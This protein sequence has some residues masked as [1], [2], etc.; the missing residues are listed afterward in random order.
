MAERNNMKLPP[1]IAIQKCATGRESIAI[2][3]YSLDMGIPC[4]FVNEPNEVPAGWMPVG[5]FDFVETIL[6]KRFLPD[7]FPEFCQ[8]HIGREWRIETTT[9]PEDKPVFI[10]PADE[11]KRFNGYIRQPGDHQWPKP[12]IV[13]EIIGFIQ[14]F[15]YYILNGK[16]L[17]GEWYPTEET[18]NPDPIPTAPQLPEE[19]KIPEDWSG[20]LDFGNTKDGRF[21]LVEAH[22][23]FACGWYGESNDYPTYANWLIQGWNSIQ[24][25]P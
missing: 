10:K 22:P 2:Q 24:K 23:P 12:W 25:L 6:G 11:L 18:P 7:H 5:G 13:Q 9:L 8:T 16:I 1:G 4:R 19:L 15:R 17:A 14:E 21:L 3:R 20:T